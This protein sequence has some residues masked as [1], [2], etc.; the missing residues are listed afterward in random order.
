MAAAE[1]V[2]GYYETVGAILAYKDEHANDEGAGDT[3]QRVEGRRHQTDVAFS[4][5]T[6]GPVPGWITRYG[7]LVPAIVRA[8]ISNGSW[9]I[10][11]RWLP[12]EAV[13]ILLERANKETDALASGQATA[14][15]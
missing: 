14:P 1:P 8:P 10:E 11:G 6:D 3:G 2:L 12:D 9:E 5:G 7:F 13:R 4:Y 15:P